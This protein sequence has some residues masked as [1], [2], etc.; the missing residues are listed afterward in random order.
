M[1]LPIAAAD[2]SSM[3]ENT[4]RTARDRWS[5]ARRPAIRRAISMCL[6]AWMAILVWWMRERIQWRLGHEGFV[7]GYTLLGTVVALFALPVRKRLV[8]SKLGRVAYWQQAHHYTGTFCMLVYLLHA[9]WITNGWFESALALSFWIIAGSGVVSAYV[10]RTAPRWLR[11]AGIQVLRDDIP[12]LRHGLEQQAYTI[13]ITAAGTADTAA[14]ADH[15]RSGLSY[16][17]GRPRNWLYRLLPTG[18]LRRRLL[19]G[20]EGIDRYVNDTGREQRRELSRLVQAR[21]DL[22]FQSAIQHRIRL[23]SALHTLFLGVFM[24]LVLVHVVIAHW[25]SFHG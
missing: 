3:D 13:A 19:A 12:S 22:D 23:W 24:T 14:L 8:D 4:T 21:D 2:K 25:Y 5:W 6:V 9:G 15:Y 16:Y 17:F 18:T 11:A 20:L 7:T 10:N 1:S